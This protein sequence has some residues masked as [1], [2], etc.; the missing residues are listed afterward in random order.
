MRKGKHILGIGKQVRQEHMIHRIQ[1][2][3]KRIQEKNLKR[4]IISDDDLPTIPFENQSEILLSTSPTQHYHISVDSCQ[5][6]Q[7]AQWL[8][9]CEGDPAVYVGI[10]TFIIFFS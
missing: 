6:V 5:K 3:N 9:K 7:L 1:E 4:Q 10:S 8:S 2:R